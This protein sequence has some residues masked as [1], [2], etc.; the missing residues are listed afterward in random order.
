MYKA[1]RIGVVVPAFNEE[2]LIEKTITNVPP[3]VDRIVVVDDGSTDE[4]SIKVA[5]AAGADARIAA[6]SHGANLG[7]GSALVSGYRHLL[8]ES[9]GEPVDVAVVM[10][11]DAQMD[12]D[13]LPRLLDALVEE[14]FDAAKGNRFL[15]FGQEL[16]S[17][18]RHR[19]F[20]NV[21]LT[22]ITKFA[23][24]YW[25]LF[26][27]QNGY[28]AITSR[29]LRSMDLS[30][31][32]KGYEVENAFL[33]EANI[34]G[35]RIKDVAMPAQYGTEQSTIK[36]HRFIPRVLR[37]MTFGFLRRIWRRYVV[38]NFH[39]VALFFYSG[40]LFVS[41]GLGFG[42]WTVSQTVG[43]EAATAGTV[44]L[45]VVPFLM[46]FQLL[47]AAIILDILNEP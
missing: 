28:Y 26:D 25:S 45:S 13:Q 7:L 4:T 10:A 9:S 15:R 21:I 8:D 19:L 38:V 43:P 34:V 3:F 24:G 12:P 42:V 37:L 11:G 35:A 5:A 40:L 31:L 47:L 46:G 32:A 30:R 1:Q 36:L 2:E 6:V 39:P 33:I 17:M 16:R 14:G 29:L 23:S 41:W 44:M 20:G 18:P 27:T 22:L